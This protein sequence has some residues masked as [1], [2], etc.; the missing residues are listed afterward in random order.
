MKYLFHNIAKYR[1]YILFSAKAQLKSE[2]ANLSL[3]WLWWILEP[4]F[5]MLVYW[6]VYT[7]IFH[8]Q[9]EY[10]AAVINIGVMYWSF[11]SKCATS[12]V[13]LIRRNSSI[14]SKVS[15]PK[16]IFVC[17]IMAVNGF[18]MVCAILPLIGFMTFYGIRVSWGILY[19]IPATISFFVMVFVL[20]CWFMHIGV[21][22]KDIE[23]VVPLVLRVLFFLSGV[24]YPIDVRLG[25]EL[26]D[27]MLKINPFATIIT[28]AR[29][30]ILYGLPSHWI[31]LGVHFAI[32][33][34]M[35]I[36]IIALIKKYESQYI[37]LV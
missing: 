20:C 9:T 12:S 29:G 25:A 27:I 3:G 19:V 26:A 37:K 22:I 5:F 6:F 1:E 34:V 33:V 16:F 4:T 7:V 2:L 35:G 36:I 23:R 13:N 8:R 15:I 32:F 18:K 24:F 31:H 30:A 21:Y 14:L 28:D 17:T 10:I 11:F